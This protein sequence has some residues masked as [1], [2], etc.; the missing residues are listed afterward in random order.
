MIGAFLV[1]LMARYGS[2]AIR[3]HGIPE[4]MEK[5]LT[6]DSRI[7]AR[8]IVLKP[9]SAAISIGTG[10]P[11]GAEGADHRDRQRDRLGARATVAD[12]IAGTADAARGR[13]GGRDGGDL[14]QPGVGGAAGD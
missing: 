12:L 7:P 10:G 1:G 4:A 5:I 13:C 6:A 9:L 8:I 3:G 14:R 11:F 2:P